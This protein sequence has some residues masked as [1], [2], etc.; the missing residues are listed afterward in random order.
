MNTK[1]IARAG[2]LCAFA[3]VLGYI[4]SLL[5]PF[6]PIAGF[7]IGLSNIPVLFALSVCG[8]KQAFFIM[9][10]KI[11]VTALW[12]SG[13]FALIY[14]LSGGILAFLAMCAAKKLKMSVFGAGMCGGVFHNI[15]QLAA[16]GM[17]LDNINVLYL[18]PALI[19]LGLAAGFF[20]GA[21]VKLLVLRL[22][23]LF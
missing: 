22:S 9:I 11:L 18:A 8:K 12:F 20:V 6:V 3:A 15:G 7:K 13:F 14:S 10:A 4:E 19:I 23:H 2:L 21:V 17:I 5:P 1:M 16:A